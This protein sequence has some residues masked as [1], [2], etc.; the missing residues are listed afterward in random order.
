MLEKDVLVREGE[1]DFVFTSMM[2]GAQTQ[3]QWMDIIYRM[4]RFVHIICPE[5]LPVC[6]LSLFTF[7]QM[8][9]FK[10]CPARIVCHQRLDNKTARWY[11]LIITDDFNQTSVF[12]KFHPCAKPY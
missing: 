7:D 4:P 3:S 11:F 8:Q 9:V 6:L 2:L 12:P 10:K 1:V 5:N